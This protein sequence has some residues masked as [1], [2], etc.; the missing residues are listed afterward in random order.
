LVADLLRIWGLCLAGF[1]VLW[2]VSFVRRDVSIVDIFWGPAFVAGLLLIFLREGLRTPWQLLHLALVAIWGLRLALHIAVRGHGKGEDRR[3]AAMREKNGP[4]FT[5]LS[6]FTVFG[7]QATLVAILSAPLV[8]VQRQPIERPLV[9]GI[10]AG[11]WLIG[12]L[13]EAV[14]DAQ[15][16]AFQRNPASRGKVMNTG[17]WRTS[18]HPNYFGEACLW[19]GYG[20]FALAVAGGI[21]TLYAPVLMNLLLLRVSGVPMLEAGIEERRPGYREYIERTSSF[22]PW[23]PRSAGRAGGAR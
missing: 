18:R 12:F 15:L 19:W 21:W 16:L 8:A 1:A 9:A 20:V 2:A 11:L 5:W 23:F 17:L 10:G 22:I 3:Y 13:F 14:G 7:L 4:R 6:L